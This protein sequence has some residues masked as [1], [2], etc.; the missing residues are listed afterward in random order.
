MQTRILILRLNRQKIGLI[1]D[2]ADQVY[3]VPVENI[4]PPPDGADFVIAVARH[5][6]VLLVILELE[7]LL[8]GEEHVHLQKIKVP[9]MAARESRPPAGDG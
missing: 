2:E 8:S 5:Q 1:V 6:N 4:Q 3:T 9:V 7:R